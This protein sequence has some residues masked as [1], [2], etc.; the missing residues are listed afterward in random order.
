MESLIAARW[1]G[2]YAPLVDA[3]FRHQLICLGVLID[4]QVGRD[5]TYAWG[6]LSG[7]C[8]HHAYELA[9]NAAEVSYLLETVADIADR[10]RLLPAVG[11]A[12]SR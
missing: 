11:A 10:L 5:A 12:A 4:A 3:P 9:P 8:H 1:I 2:R 7:A 6:A